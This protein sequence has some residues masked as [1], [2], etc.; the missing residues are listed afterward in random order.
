M[1][2]VAKGTSPLAEWKEE[3]TLIESDVYWAICSLYPHLITF[4][5]CAAELPELALYVC[6]LFFDRAVC[7]GGGGMCVSVCLY[8]PDPFSVAASA[9]CHYGCCSEWNHMKIKSIFRLTSPGIR[10]PTRK[11]T[12]F[13]PGFR[14]RKPHF[15][16]FLSFCMNSSVFVLAWYVCSIP[17]K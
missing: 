14:G 13:H 17:T 1:R 9:K 15:I 4:S 5:V 12:P 8:V 7:G 10:G 11:E 2:A 6:S 3:R 16:A